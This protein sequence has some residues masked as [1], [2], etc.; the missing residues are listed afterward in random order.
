[1]TLTTPAEANAQC[2]KQ[3]KAT[4]KVGGGRG[5]GGGQE[6]GGGETSLIQVPCEEVSGGGWGWNLSYPGALWLGSVRNLSQINEWPWLRLQRP[7]PNA[8]SK[9]KQPWRWEGD[10]G[11]GG[12]GGARRGWGWNLSYP[13]ALWLGSVRDLDYA[14]RGQCPN[15]LKLKVGGGLKPLLSR[16]LVIRKCP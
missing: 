6:G 3:T 2:C 10:R 9:L 4:L 15:K 11:G 16:C 1:M 7:I 12:G 8:A 13:G 5:G 14:C